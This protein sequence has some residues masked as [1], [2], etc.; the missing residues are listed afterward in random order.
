MSERIAE[1]D[2][3][4]ENRVNAAE[5]EASELVKLAQREAIRIQAEAEE[6]KKA[7][8]DQALTIVADA[9]NTADWI[10]ADAR[11]EAADVRAEAEERAR[12]LIAD[13]RD[14]AAGVRAEGLELVSNLRE[15]GDALRA[16][17]DRLLRDIQTIHSRMTRDLDRVDTGGDAGSVTASRRR[18][19]S[20]EPE[21]SLSPGGEVL[22]VPEFLPRR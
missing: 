6:A 3:A 13:A 5:E 1:G 15:M 20:E 14:T 18:R 2:R 12:T 11:G 9:H 4:A 16:N 19:P 21:P 8:G 10:V 7:A 17:A 22:D